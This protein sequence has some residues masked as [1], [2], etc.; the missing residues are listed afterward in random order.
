MLSHKGTVRIETPRLILRQFTPDDAPDVFHGWMSD[1][2]VSRFMT[3]LPHRELFETETLLDAWCSLYND[4][5]V[6]NWALVLRENLRVI[7]NVSVTDRSDR[8]E[9]CELGYCLAPACWGQGLMP[10]AVRAVITYLFRD[11]GYHRIV[12]RH[13][14]D[15]PASGRVMQKCGMQ[16]EGTAR[17]AYH[18]REGDFSDLDTYA[19]ISTD[20]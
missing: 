17:G 11:V 9:N 5:R 18:T 19:V 8:H 1:P 15:N 12:A 6:Y 3:W 7:G 14:R 2:A 10:E 16:F 20:F 13:R 4:P